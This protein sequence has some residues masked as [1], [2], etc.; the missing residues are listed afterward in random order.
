MNLYLVA[1]FAING[2]LYLLYLLEEC[3]GLDIGRPL[4]TDIAEHFKRKDINFMFRC[5]A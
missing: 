4:L 5:N 2:E 1:K 3:R